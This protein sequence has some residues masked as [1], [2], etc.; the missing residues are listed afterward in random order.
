MGENP[1]NFKYDDQVAAM[2]YLM[3]GDVMYAEACPKL[4]VANLLS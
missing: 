1:K 4:R 3:P 2:K